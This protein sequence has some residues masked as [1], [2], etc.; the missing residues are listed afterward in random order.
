MMVLLLGAMTLVSCEKYEDGRP[1]KS[2]LNKFESM[3][4][5]AK[6]V[7]WERDGFDWKVSFE[8]GS[9]SARIDHEAWYDN[10]GRWLKTETDL[11]LS[12]VPKEIV[13][14]LK[15]SEEYGSAIIDSN[16]VEYVETPDGDYYRFELRI[17]GVEIAVKVDKDG[18]VGIAGI[19]R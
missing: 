17:G 12:V 1:A 8:T 9:G 4:S 16:D 2:V 10:D 7:E 18:N 5:G 14:F 3:Y 11:R 15:A 6:D 13:D 19:D